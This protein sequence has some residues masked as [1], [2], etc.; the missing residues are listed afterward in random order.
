MR[1]DEVR[2][3]GTP[4]RVLRT[5]PDPQRPTVLF[6]NAAGMTGELA[7]GLGAWTTAAGFDL[8]TWDQ[9]GSPGPGRAD[10]ALAVHVEDGLR[11]L[12][13]LGVGEV[14]LLGWCTGASVALFLAHRLGRRARSLVTVDGAY[15]FDGVPGAPLGNAMYDMCGRIVADVTTAAQYHELTRPRGTETTVLGLERAPW[16]VEHVTRPYRQDE[17]ALIRYA[18]AIRS[19]CD[20]E[21]VAAWR[22]VTCPT[23][24][25]AHRDDRMVSCRQSLR[26]AGVSGADLDLRARGGHYGLFAGGQVPARVTGYLQAVDPA[27]G[28]RAGWAA[29][30]R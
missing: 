20:Y 1:P 5:D 10:S 26:A 22:E 23:L 28:R 19:A 27:G 24:V 30:A 14:H 9:R 4:L 13:A 2:V 6:V 7:A 12:D 17:D 29:P 11:V 18:H 21:P 16:L 25:I 8:V 15:L 3:D